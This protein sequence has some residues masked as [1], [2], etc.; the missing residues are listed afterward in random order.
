VNGNDSFEFTVGS[1][2]GD[3]DA[4]DNV[5]EENDTSEDAGPSEIDSCT[6]INESG[7]YELTDDVESSADGD[8]VCI[9]VRASDVVLDGNG[10]G[11][12]GT[13][14]PN[15]TGLLVY[16]GTV[17]GFDDTEPLT[18]VTVRDIEVADW[19]QGVRAGPEAA[20]PGPQIRLLDVSV[21][22][23]AGVSLY[24]TDDSVLRNVNVTGGESG[25]YLWEAS[26][27]TAESLTVTDTTDVGVFLAQ[28]VR[29]SRL[30]GVEVV[31]N[32]GGGI[33]FS[34]EASGNV[35]T[36]ATVEGND[37]YGVQF[38]DSAD[39]VVE[40]SQ[41]AGTDGP[42]VVADPSGGDRLEDVTIRDDSV[43]LEVRSDGELGLS[44]V[45]LS[46]NV[47][48]STPEAGS[49]VEFEGDSDA[50]MRLGTVEVSEIDAESPGD[51]LSD[52]AVT[53]A[54]ADSNVEATFEVPPVDDDTRARLFGVAGDDW[55]P[56]EGAAGPTVVLSGTETVA[57]FGVPVENETTT[58]TG[59]PNK[60]STGTPDEM[61]TTTDTPSEEPNETS[62]GE[63]NETSATTE[64][65]SLT[66]DESVGGDGTDAI[67][68]GAP[69][70]VLGLAG[71][72]FV[73]TRD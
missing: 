42:A 18:N 34:T 12:I 43:A 67:V 60:T 49:V 8:G 71:V 72:L 6:T 55:T 62:T 2:E 29:D 70:S 15:S 52:R 20:S 64:S 27:V 59:T 9:H 28:N 39:N 32:D 14:A 36:G 48:V 69:L 11:V 73:R 22:N 30:S 16:N 25:L 44:N 58:P 65:S 46:R 35:V 50:P 10:N 4:D 17:D 56:V 5:T 38:S 13:G 51:P 37:E 47:T 45:S 66:T 31:D 26:N 68:L 21:R 1:T 61:T 19:D 23:A 63:P 24:G 57:P 41:I 7:T 53:V 40:Q 54:N 3:D 33:Y